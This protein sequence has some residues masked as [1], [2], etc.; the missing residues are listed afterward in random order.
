VRRPEGKFA[1]YTS[2]SRGQSRWE[3]TTER[4]KKAKGKR[5]RGDKGRVSDMHGN[6]GASEIHQALRE[7]NKCALTCAKR[8][9]VSEWSRGAHVI[10]LASTSL[11]NALRTGLERSTWKIRAPHPYIYDERRR[12]LRVAYET[13][14]QKR[15]R[16]VFHLLSQ[17]ATQSRLATLAPLC[18]RRHSNFLIFH[19]HQKLRRSIMLK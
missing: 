12:C 17:K 19:R 8:Y 3:E 11:H 13:E 1:K 9:R 16:A 5:A 2:A 18:A 6:M 4:R 14:L 7:E 10:C 15:R